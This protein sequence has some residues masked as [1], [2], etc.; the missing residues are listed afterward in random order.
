MSELSKRRCDILGQMIMEPDL[1]F[2][3]ISAESLLA[4]QTS[5]A[6]LKDALRAALKGDPVDAANSAEMLYR[7]LDA[8]CLSILNAGRTSDD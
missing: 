4:D 6:W 5:P 8:R 3:A 1:R 2:E 7:C